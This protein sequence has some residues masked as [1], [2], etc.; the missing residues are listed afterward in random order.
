MRPIGYAGFA[1]VQLID[2]I[3][4]S[5]LCLPS[6]SLPYATTLVSDVVLTQR[7]LYLCSDFAQ[8]VLDSYQ[9]LLLYVLLLLD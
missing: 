1:P 2:V 6:D 3:V 9:L 8:F 7:Y 5:N 4:K